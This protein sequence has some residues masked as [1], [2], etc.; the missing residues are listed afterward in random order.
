VL[1]AE[2]DHIEPQPG[3]TGYIVGDRAYY[4]DIPDAAASRPIVRTRNGR[5][6]LV[7]PVTG[8]NVDKTITYTLTW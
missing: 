2:A 6:Q 3:G 1:L 5:Q 7:V 4:I 8:L